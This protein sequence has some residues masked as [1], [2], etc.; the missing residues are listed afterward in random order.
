MKIIRQLIYLV[1]L[2]QTKQQS[3]NIYIFFY[4]SMN[5]I[6]LNIKVFVNKEI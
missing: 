1:Q 5:I 6:K 2:I 4:K 3:R